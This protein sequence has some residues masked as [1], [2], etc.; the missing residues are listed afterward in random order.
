ML[1]FTNFYNKQPDNKNPLKDN[2]ES[3]KP[4]KRIEMGGLVIGHQED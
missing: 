4:F 3:K 1:S 2:K